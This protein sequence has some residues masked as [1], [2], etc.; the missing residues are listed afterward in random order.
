MREPRVAWLVDRLASQGW[1]RDERSVDLVNRDGSRCVEVVAGA[2]GVRELDAKVLRVARWVTQGPARHACL[3]LLGSQLS[4]ERLRKEWN[5][6]RTLVRPDLGR[7]IALIV[8]GVT[9]GF[10][11]RFPWLHPI[12]KLV[13]GQPT[14]PTRRPASRG[15]MSPTIFQV[16]KLVIRHWLLKTGPLS[17]RRL[18]VESGATYPTVARAL[19][20]LEEC[21]ELERLPNRRVQL[22]AFPQKTWLEMLSLSSSL[23]RPLS[24]VDATGRKL[25]PWVLLKRL[26]AMKPPGVALGGV[27]SARHWDRHFDL[28]GLPRLDVVVHAPHGSFD[29]GFVKQL[30]SALR[31]SQSPSA[32]HVLVVHSL[33]RAEALFDEDRAGKLPYADPVE[34]LLDLHELRLTTQADELIERLPRGSRR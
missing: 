32:E 23:R 7:R 21:A 33:P 17:R 25:E 26:E 34:T 24:Y 11:P 5:M 16:L 14:Q 13:H 18:Q 8:E 1:R 29:P 27:Q 10:E 20:K 31:P 19:R 3:V 15:A 12:T 2:Q 9:A 30:D 28:N 22:R 4:H 6:I